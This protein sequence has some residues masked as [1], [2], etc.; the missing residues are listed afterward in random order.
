M[1]NSFIQLTPHDAK[2]E[3]IMFLIHFQT[4]IIISI[5]FKVYEEFN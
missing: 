2:M 5:C 4:T 1:N 3:H